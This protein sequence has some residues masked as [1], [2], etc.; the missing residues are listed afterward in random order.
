M[1]LFLLNGTLGVAS[2]WSSTIPCFAFNDIRNYIICYLT[3]QKLPVI[4]PHYNNYRGRTQ[5]IYD[6]NNKQYMECMGVVNEDKDY[7]YIIETHLN[8][9]Y[10]AKLFDDISFNLTGATK[11]EKEKYEKAEHKRPIYDFKPKKLANNVIC[12]EKK[13]VQ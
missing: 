1:P 7:I 6:E 10:K 3:E 9:M 13:R 2:G 5:F 8:K 4:H 12:I 11:E